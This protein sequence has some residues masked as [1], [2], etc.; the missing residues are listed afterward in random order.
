MCLD[1]IMLLN[2]FWSVI[3][4]ALEKDNLGPDG[5]QGGLCSQDLRIENL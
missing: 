1:M 2:Y 5:I 3:Q 4:F